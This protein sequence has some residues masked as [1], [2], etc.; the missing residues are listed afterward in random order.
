MKTPIL[1]ALPVA[2]VAPLT[3]DVMISEIMYHPADEGTSGEFIEI[4]NNGAEPVDVSSWSITRG[5]EF[6]I[7]AET[8]V[9][10]G[11]H[12]VIA[13]DLAAFAAKYPTVTGAVG[14]WSGRLSNSSNRIELVDADG[15][16]VDEVEYSDDGDWA[17]RAKDTVADFGH[18][19]WHWNNPADGGGRSLELV[20]AGF[21]NSS[22]QNWAASGVAGGTPGAAN[23]VA[24]TDIAPLIR[25]VGHFPLVPKSSEPVQV[26][27]RINDDHGT[28][29][30][31]AVHWRVDGGPSFTNAAMA[32]DGQHGDG[33]A[34][35][36]VYGAT[37]PPEAQGT[38]IEFYVSA[39]DSGSH[40]RTWPAPS[41]DQAGQ[42][43]QATNCLYQV[44]DTVY[45]GSMPIYRMILRA[46][47][48]QELTRIN[49]NA[50]PIAG[51]DQT[52][53]E[54]EMNATAIMSGGTGTELRYQC[55]LRNRG[56]GS[57]SAQPQSYRI[58]F[59]NEQPWDDVT[60]LNLNT[61]NT[62]YQLI[63]SAIFRRAGAPMAA[64]RAVQVRVNAVNPTSAG[65][66]S[67]GFYV[68]NEVVGSEFADLH[69]PL[70]S[71]GN[72][73]RVYDPDRTATEPGGDL[74]DLS[75]NPNPAL[76]DPTPYRENYF[77]KTNSS[78]D[79]WSDLIGV[80]Q[81]LA[82]GQSPTLDAPVY[83]LDYVS[84]VNA[85]VDVREW[86]G[87]FAMHT[88][89]DNTE[90][91][92]SNGYGDDY[93][94]YI[95]VTDPRARLIPY[96]LD[97]VFGRSSSSSVTRGLFEMCRI[98]SLTGSPPAPVNP[99]MKHPEFAPVYYSELK[100]MIDGAFAPANFN[101][102]AAEMLGGWVDPA[103]I[104]S[105]E[106]FNAQRTAW[107]ATQIPLGLSVTTAPA[108]LSGYPHTTTASAA[109]GGRANAI[110]TRSVKVNGQAVTWTGWTAT[111]S[112]PAVALKPGINRV[113]IQ[114]FDATGKETERMS[115]DVWYD[116][117]SVQSV[118][119]NITTD[120]TWTAAG[121]PWLVSA[122][123]SVA[124]GATLT[125]EAGTTVYLAG[126]ATLTVA[127]GGRI[128]APG[129]EAARI[130][131]TTAPGSGATWSGIV[132]NGA[133]GTPR[134]VI[135]HASIAGNSTRAIDVNA[136]DVIF[137]HLEFA[138]T[139]QQYISLDGASFVVSD[140]VFPEATAEFELV[141]GTL[142]V[143]A[144][145]RGIL[146]H[147]FFGSP[148]GYNDTVD[149]TGGQR[150]GPILQVLNCVFDGTDDD[151]LDLDGTD[152]WVEGNI[153]LH[154]HK[155]G[156]PDSSAAVSGGSNGADTSEVTII[157]NIFYDVDH[158]LTAK[159][160]N[161]YT[162]RNNTV[163]H[164]TISGGLDIEGG[165]LNLQDAIPAP[166]TTYAAGL[167]AEDNVLVDC[168][169]LLR[170]Y[171]SAS[172]A[173]SISG[174][175]MKLPWTGTGSGNADLDPLLVHV[176]ELAETDFNSWEGA[177]VMK[178][179]LAL[180]PNSPARG[181][182]GNG[183]D[184][185]GVI[186]LGV[187]LHADVGAVTALDSIQ[188]NV[189]PQPLVASWS[190]GYTH[191]RWRLDGGVWSAI[192][193]IGQVISLSGLGAGAHTLEVSGRND[194]LYFQDDA[195]FGG[196]AVIASYAWTIDPG[197]VPP[198]GDSPV[199]IHEVL[200]RNV[201]TLGFSGTFPD[202]IEL[203]NSGNAPV[204]ISGWGLSDTP[205]TPYRYSFPTGTILAPGAYYVVYASTAGIVPSPRA[206][207]ALSEGGEVLSLTKAN[208]DLADRVSFGQ[209]LPDYSIGRREGDGG[210]DLCKPSFGGPNVVAAQGSWSDIRL[211]EW[212]ASAAVSS[213]TDFIELYN[214]GSLPLNLGG[215]FLTDNP[216]EWPDRSPI[217]PLT[218]IPGGGYAL[219]K[220]DGDGEQ[221][222][223][224]VAFKLSASQGEIGLFTPQLGRVDEVVYGP[225][226]TDI[227]Q[228][229]T[230]DGA[231]QVAF[232]TQPTPGGP[233]PGS[234]VVNEVQ[235]QTLIP[236][237]ATWKYRATS[238][239][240]AGTF[241][242]VGFDDSAWSS[243]GQLLYI[244]TAALPSA[245]GFVKTT[246]LAGNASNSNRPFATNYFRRHFTWNGPT[247]DVILRARIMLD[248]GAVI[249]LNGQPAA[250]VR[251]NEGDV[252]YTTTSNATVDDAIEE[253]IDLPASLLVQGDNVI[254]VEVHQVNT[255]SSDVVWGMKL[256]ALVQ[257]PTTVPPL[258]IN[259][260]LVHN[261]SLPNP[262]SSLAG[263]VE[264][265]N[266]SAG[267]IDISGMSLSTDLGNPRA[268]VMPAGTTLGAGGHLVLGCD[269]S[270]PASAANTGFHL[271]RAGGAIYLFHA[272]SIGGGL[273]DSVTFGNQLADLSIGRVPDG[274]GPFV[275]ATPT[276][277]AANAAAVIG[278]VS[279]V[280]LNEWLADPASGPDGFELYNSGTQ[281]VAIGGNYLSDHLS[282]KRRQL[283]PPLSFIGTGSDRWLSFIA[284]G[285][286]ATPGRVNFALDNDGGALGL[287][288]A[289]GVQ[290]D[291]V[292]FGSQADGKS[293][294][295][296]PDG[297][298]TFFVMTPTLGTANVQGSTDS[299]GDGMPD[300]WEIAH[301]FNP[302]SAADG[303]LD[304]DHDGISN[305]NEYLAGT[306]P[307]NA[308]SRFDGKVSLEGGAVV[309]HFTA[310]AGRTY[311]VQ[312]SEALG[313]GAWQKLTDLP[314]QGATGE[315]S[316]NDPGAS[317][318]P[319]RFYRIVTPAVSGP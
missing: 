125:I 105:M 103:V 266:P 308:A 242:Q 2:L 74:R 196:D 117:G 56:N 193:P 29:A 312:Y 255:G 101:A 13:A 295:R 73:Y 66:P 61:Q 233:N 304:A 90:T 292:A 140:C 187:C 293:Q 7:P 236:V 171:D 239:S 277:G 11:G 130:R 30:G 39:A 285:S 84:A 163:V 80:T 109:L 188:V 205:A 3:A 153:F 314:A 259:E 16:K 226:T 250:R 191:Y 96:D 306:D 252:I 230:P 69:F 227:A 257:V 147:C 47:D 26:T 301:G 215:G 68:A 67:Y 245:T 288:S 121:G 237:N 88:L 296:F 218:F 87:F 1:C 249:Y 120:T 161:Y 258:R 48:R 70:D 75:N 31:A 263:W 27:A 172:T 136:G 238:T 299:D 276:R 141:H 110:T 175:L 142:G 22:G 222:P 268:W 297:S 166:P 189:G 317:G 52:Q 202:M 174:N 25:E 190:S 146:R 199:K 275:L 197:Y 65:A 241:Q 287:F 160:G 204:N 8:V 113:L 148:M 177:Q 269:P 32:D 170:N 145:G 307:H 186:P 274:T 85:K 213:A 283:V 214:R 194:A 209:Q 4:H 40:S 311:T 318:K 106:T 243:G 112:A 167:I 158:A 240:Y 290:L 20:E 98:V 95:G 77:K 15:V 138:N 99:F 122:S 220:A 21:D 36:G 50:P 198:A 33:L 34:N 319:H 254:A 97:S 281:P 232:F 178:Q 104:S 37:L 244:E 201:A 111:W 303:A 262:D 224:H 313:A 184:K 168:Q 115:E 126:G 19:G 273:R 57:R 152:T 286:A 316:V 203:H 6:T 228:G 248:D 154:C 179:W 116:D 234:T 155:N 144:G 200:A 284:D 294:G 131:F 265:E 212:L 247:D 81:A 164:Q 229:R 282:D 38:I 124:S 45:S 208:G 210:W 267:Q 14:G 92:L 43:E 78:E 260:V 102:T 18:F 231:G 219:F 133:A 305:A 63:G 79:N 82:K 149:F 86:M 41:L 24:A 17:V 93:N 223:D 59:L 132:I 246:T 270:L 151:M 62:P 180:K 271:N 60:G 235:T 114:A 192:T 291:A 256:D 137:D 278:S 272:P 123:I 162:F 300:D 310:Q 289:G 5:V 207:Y 108:V 49:T 264:L 211:N 225:Q 94:I 54:V 182:A 217:A 12:L 127:S 139:T 221:G 119:A 100:R 176:P 89:A 9:P 42:P 181:T 309:I 143:K 135:S 195:E 159:Q 280:K 302:S 157:G 150:P 173:V 58:N 183:R 169:Q 206:N 83:Q 91:N 216:V 279:A 55:G 28:L 165:V 107:V 128:M 156:A 51:L 118:A 23:S 251:M 35:D 129:S 71:S 298:G 253:S 261:Q 185:G 46:V 64:S 76:A 315:T 44:D 10:A 72:A 134:S 53:S